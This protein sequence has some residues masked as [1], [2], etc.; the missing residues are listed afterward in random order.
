MPAPVTRAPRG[1]VLLTT[2]AVGGVWTH[3]LDLARGLER[4]DIETMLVVLGP[5]PSASQMADAWAVRRVSLI[6]TGLP[7]DWMATEPA[8]VLEVGAALRGLARGGRASLIH[9]HSPA[10]AAGGHLGAPV[11][12][13]CH[14]CLATWWSAV[15][16]GPMP[17]DFSWRSQLLWQGMQA[18]DALVAPTRAFAQD[19]SRTYDIPLPHVVWNGR[20]ASGEGQRGDRAPMV[21]TSGRLWDEG[22]NIGVLDAAAALIKAPFNA[23]G[24]LN[25]PNGS[26]VRLRHARALGQLSANEVAAWLRLAPIYASSALYEPFGLG[27]LE[28][29]QAGCALVLSD[30]AT[31]RELWDGAAM[32]VDPREPKAYAEVFTRL[33]C[34]PSER[35]TLGLQA[36]ARAARYSLDRMSAGYLE[37]Y[38]RLQPRLKAPARQ[39]AAA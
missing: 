6:D 30:I 28:A 25:G 11:I 8:E 33:L 31:L 27:I 34:D 24:A 4:A 9:L 15:K 3:T 39:E 1:R 29:A 32:F 22:K 21:V 16:D 23:A 38:G 2:D 13:A 12:G 17:A 26:G 19:V 36:Q 18:C 37:L 7:L 35:R 14:S 5:S 20:Q 10:F